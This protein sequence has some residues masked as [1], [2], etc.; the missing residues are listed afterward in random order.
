MKEKGT[1]DVFQ[2]LANRLEYDEVLAILIFEDG[3]GSFYLVPP[4]ENA[5][6]LLSGKATSLRHDFDSIAE[7]HEALKEL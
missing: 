7:F 2:Q 4:S 5:H 6:S 3:S 1:E